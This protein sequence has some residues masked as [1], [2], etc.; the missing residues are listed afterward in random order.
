MLR[1]FDKAHLIILRALGLTSALWGT[2]TLLNSLLVKCWDTVSVAT[3]SVDTEFDLNPNPVG[4]KFSTTIRHTR[5][6]ALVP[7]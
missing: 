5:K 2:M 3:C 6:L 1:Y 4:F 7:G